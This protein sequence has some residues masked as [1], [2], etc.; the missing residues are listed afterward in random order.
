M[1]ARQGLGDRLKTYAELQSELTSVGG[2]KVP[3]IP[4]S[5]FQYLFL[6]N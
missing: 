6:D 3:S 4:S 5:P 1:A 2:V